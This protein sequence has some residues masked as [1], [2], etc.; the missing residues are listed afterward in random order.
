MSIVFDRGSP[1]PGKLVH[2]LITTEAS[3]RGVVIATRPGTVKRYEG[4]IM[5]VFER[6]AKA[7]V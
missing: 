3:V 5:S 6:Y 1:V 2:R 4:A 7:R